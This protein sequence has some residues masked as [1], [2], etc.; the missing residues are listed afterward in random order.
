MPHDTHHIL[1]NAIG[2]E[3]DIEANVALT[4][5]RAHFRQGWHMRPANIECL[6]RRKCATIDPPLKAAPPLRRFIMEHDQRAIA[7]ALHIEFDHIRP[8]V[9]G[10]CER[11]QCVLRRIR[12][13]TSVADHSCHS[14]SF[15]RGIAR[16]LAY[17]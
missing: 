13:S 9:G 16:F 12:R 1:S 8:L 2:F 11:G 6:H 10:Q 4:G 17:D 7:G 15:E 3:F 14:V 5:K